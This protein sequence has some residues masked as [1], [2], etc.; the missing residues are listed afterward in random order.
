MINDTT[1]HVFEKNMT[2]YDI[3]FG[4]YYDD[5]YEKDKF[6]FVWLKDGNAGPSFTWNAGESI[7]IPYASEK[8]KIGMADLTGILNEIKIAFPGSILELTG[9]GEYSNY[10]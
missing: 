3:L 2:R 10:L 5:D 8:T 6:Y 7:R 4:S 1:R 9:L